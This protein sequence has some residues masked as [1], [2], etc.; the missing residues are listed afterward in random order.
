MRRNEA[1]FSLI[2]TVYEM[3]ERLKVMENYQDMS[4]VYFIIDKQVRNCLT[5]HQPLHRD[6]RR[7][8]FIPLTERDLQ[9]ED[10]VR[11]RIKKM[12]RCFELLVEF[13]KTYTKKL[14]NK[15]EIRVYKY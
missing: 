2:I 7:I 6:L 10:Y 5:T 11:S 4:R 3:L 1:D 12:S 13:D 8:E 14:Y 15:N 9:C